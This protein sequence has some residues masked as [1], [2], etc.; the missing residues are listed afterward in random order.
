MDTERLVAILSG[1]YSSL[2]DSFRA[3]LQRE[4]TFLSLPKN[5]FLIEAPRPPEFVY[6]LQE[7]F[8]A[9]FV[10]EEGQR[11]IHSFWGVGD[12][13]LSPQRCFEKT[14]SEEFVQLSE[15]S[16]VW[17]LS[18]ASLGHLLELHEEART[19]YRTVLGRY[20]ALTRARLFDI[21]HRTAWQRFQKLLE[22]F[23]Q[24]EQKVS[25]E[26]IASYLGITPQSLSRIKRE[27]RGSS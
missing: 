11:K 20:Y 17:C 23:P 9:G 10:Y 24:L 4:A 2:S 3:A 1:Y 7:G 16:E 13:I 21:Q 5:H 27:H 22:Q 26:C 14:T 8:A 19:L 6:L 12:V 15:T 25:Q 18:H